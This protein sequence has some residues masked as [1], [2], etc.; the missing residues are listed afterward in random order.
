VPRRA[1]SSDDKRHALIAEEAGRVRGAR[2]IRHG[3]KY[4]ADHRRI[5]P[6]ARRSHYPLVG[7]NQ[8]PDL[9]CFTTRMAWHPQGGSRCVSGIKSGPWGDHLARCARGV[10]RI[11][12]VLWRG[13]LPVRRGR[14]RQGHIDS[15]GSSRRLHHAE[16]ERPE[17]DVEAA[18][19][20]RLHAV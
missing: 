19:A 5:D 13:A 17:I 4:R 2:W 16:S 11:A 20:T 18:S 10:N 14:W 7:R 8:Q 15:T 9:E 6:P 1:T 12:I 3:G